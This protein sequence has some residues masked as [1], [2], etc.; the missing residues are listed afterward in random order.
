[1]DIK[2]TF[3]KDIL[4]EYSCVARYQCDTCTRE[5][6]RDLIQSYVKSPYKYYAKMVIRI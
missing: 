5:K 1:M 2:F 3:C 4:K 6:G